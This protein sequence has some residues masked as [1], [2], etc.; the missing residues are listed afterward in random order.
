MARRSI[1]KALLWYRSVWRQLSSIHF[2]RGVFSAVGACTPLAL[3]KIIDIW[4][5]VEGF[6]FTLAICVIGM[7]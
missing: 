6:C 2:A 3:A 5:R 4:G 7:K 1:G